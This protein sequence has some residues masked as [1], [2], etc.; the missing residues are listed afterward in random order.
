MFVCGAVGGR[1]DCAGS[2]HRQSTVPGPGQPSGRAVFRSAKGRY[3]K[4][5]CSVAVC[6]VAIN[7]AFVCQYVDGRWYEISR[8]DQH[9]EKDCDCGYATYTPQADG[10]VRVQNCCE[11]LPN[12]TVKCSIGK[13]VVSYPDVFPLEGRFNVTF[14]GRKFETVEGR[15][16]RGEKG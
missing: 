15:G 12:T 13:A 6:F 16:G 11:R 3:C 8:Y 1:L 5:A 2:T 7:F 10:S 4:V 9:F 14:G